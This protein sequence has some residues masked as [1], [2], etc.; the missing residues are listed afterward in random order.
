MR[1]AITQR[2]LLTMVLALPAARASAANIYFMPG[3]AFFHTQLTEDR[4]QSLSADRG[5][6]VFGYVLPI[7]SASFGGFAGFRRLEIRD[8]P[9]ELS[10]NLQLVYRKLR[11]EGGR[12]VLTY[13]ENGKEKTQELNGYHLF[14]YNKTADF[15]RQRIGI[16]Y[17]ES[18]RKLPPEALQARRTEPY[19]AESVRPPII[20][21]SFAIT[22]PSFTTGSGAKSST[23]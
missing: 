12:I 2:V 9:P 13:S 10:E 14:V 3:D 1:F 7:E 16:R 17:N 4:V 11:G 21:H 23:P 8:F 18:W 19:S 15:G 22:R 5:S 20:S 6:V